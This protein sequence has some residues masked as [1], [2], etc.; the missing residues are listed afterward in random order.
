MN[1]KV[2]IPVQKKLFGTK[3][4]KGMSLCSTE[5]TLYAACA[6]SQG[7]GIELKKCESEFSSLLHCMKN[8]N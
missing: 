6:T 4:S 8:S 5:L 7:L 3:V 2:Y 1:R